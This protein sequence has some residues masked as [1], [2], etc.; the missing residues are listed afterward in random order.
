M[1]RIGHAA[2]RSIALQFSG[3]DSQTGTTHDQADHRVIGYSS[4]SGLDFLGRSFNY[5]RLYRHTINLS[6]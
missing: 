2:C 3:N 6:V 5:A 1:L 4:Q